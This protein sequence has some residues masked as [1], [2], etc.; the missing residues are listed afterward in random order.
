MDVKP[1]ENL[2]DLDRTDDIVVEKLL[3]L[4]LAKNEKK[5]HCISEIKTRHFSGKRRYS[6][7]KKSYKLKIK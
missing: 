6:E 7:T 2:K 3:K 5:T 1:S 4:K